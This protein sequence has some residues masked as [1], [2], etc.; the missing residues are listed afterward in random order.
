MKFNQIKYRLLAILIYLLWGLQVSHSQNLENI[1]KGEAFTLNGGINANQVLYFANGMED[2]RDP[3]NYFLSGNLT[4][5][6]YGWTVPLT[7]SYSNQNSSFQQPFNQ[8]G[9]SPT[10]KWITAHAG[11]RSMT[12]SKYSLNGHLFLGGGVEVNPWDKVKVSAMYG[13]FQKAVEEDTTDTGNVPA[14]KR[15]GGGIKVSIGDSKNFVDLIVFKAKDDKNSLNEPIILND[16]K[17]EENLVLGVNFAKIISERIVLKAEYANSAIT[18][19]S[20]SEGVT[21]GKIYDNLKFAF[22]PKV[23]SSYYN[24]VNAGIQYKL[25]NAGIGIAYERVDPGYRTLGSYFFNNNL[26]NIALTNSLVLFNK[27]ARINWRMGVQRNNLDKK[28]LSSLK[29]LSGAFNINFMAT[30]RLVYNASYTNFSTVVNFRSQF[31]V[32]NQVSPYENLDTLN[33]R[34]V[35]QN[36]NLSMN[37]VIN[38]SKERRQNLTVNLAYQVTNDEQAQLEQPTGSQFYNINSAYS[39]NFGPSGWTLNFAVNGN[40]SESPNANSS[41]FGPSISARKSFFEKKL[42]SSLSFSINNAYTNDQ[43]SSR[44]ANLRG[45]LNYTLLEKHQFNLNL[46]GVN[47]FSPQNEVQPKFSEFTAQVGYN[48]NFGLR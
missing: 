22:R 23:A 28:E 10:Y 2:R 6:L 9:L 41:I 4:F 5:G 20:R 27:K 8:Y 42:S 13:R 48:Y 40:I 1:G 25:R 17:P 3:Y 18:E 14:Y 47:R 36:A 19:D 34:Q 7:F 31:D 45:S 38:E 26:E 33:F 11:Y 35:A 46:T 37:Y 15:M 21:S 30:P 24:A 32:I 39:L 29:R 12:F 43:L 44:V 16:T